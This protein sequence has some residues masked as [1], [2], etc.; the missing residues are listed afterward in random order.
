MP[1]LTFRCPTGHTTDDLYR[2]NVL[3]DGAWVENPMP[4]AIPC[5]W[6]SAPAN[7]V[8]AAP[9]VRVER[10]AHYDISMGQWFGNQHEADAEARRRGLSERLTPQDMDNVTSWAAKKR[11]EFDQGEAEF[12]E[13]QKEWR[14]APH[15]AWHRENIDK[16]VYVDDAKRRAEEAGVAVS[17]D[18]IHIEGGI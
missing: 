6:C 9:A 15:F 18:K 3:V 7:R 13:T 8:P 4:D 11:A 16:G 14:E 5:Q 1:I 2:A 12:A 17:K 10:G